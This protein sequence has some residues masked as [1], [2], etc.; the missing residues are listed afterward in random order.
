MSVSERYQILDEWGRGAS[1][2]VYRARDRVSGRLV[3]VKSFQAAEAREAELLQERMQRV[4]AALAGLRHANIVPL[5][6]I[7]A[8]P[9]RLL[10]VSEFVSGSSLLDILRDRQRLDP[11]EAV[12]LVAQA[13]R[14]LARAHAAGLLHGN[15]KPSNLLVSLEGTVKVGDFGV[16]ATAA[17]DTPA[18]GPLPEALLASPGCLAPEQLLGGPLDERTDVYALGALLYRSLTGRCPFEDCTPAELAERVRASDPLPPHH[19]VPQLPRELSALAMESLARDPDQRI[20][21]ADELARLLERALSTVGTA[22][23]APPVRPRRGPQRPPERPRRRRSAPTLLS[24][25]AAALLVL[26]ALALHERAGRA[27]VASPPPP[28]VTPATTLRA[29]LGPQPAPA[30]GPPPTAA[31]T[32]AAAEAPATAAVPAPV[33]ERLSP[34]PPQP[35]QRRAAAPVRRSP[36]ATRR[37][38]PRRAVAVREEAEATPPVP[39]TATDPEPT[40]ATPA[41]VVARPAP[42]PERADLARGVVSLDHPLLEGLLEIKV[43]GRRAGLVRLGDPGQAPPGA[44]ATASF[45]IAPGARRLEVR[46]LSATHRVET[47]WTGELEWEAGR[48]RALEFV[49]DGPQPEWRLDLAGGSGPAR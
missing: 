35:P 18:A 2:V 17:G 21:T 25:V 33:A 9:D 32:T 12:V 30:P 45:S 27:V 24:A 13:C 49:L 10:V 36:A 15:L 39:S 43:D 1:G 48:F 3:A 14:G 4:A 29:E 26:A 19:W 34:P 8:A 23:V 28:P 20:G 47:E 5:I 44:P 31:P 6:E 37:Q 41:R 38:P 40:P 42:A 16:V 11:P 22:T 7:E 46:V